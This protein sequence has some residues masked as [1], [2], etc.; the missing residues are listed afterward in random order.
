MYL[1]PRSFFLSFPRLLL[2]QSLCQ[3]FW[4][5]KRE[6]GHLLAPQARKRVDWKRVEAVVGKRRLRV[7]ALKAVGFNV[8][9]E[10]EGKDENAQDFHDRISK[11]D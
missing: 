10:A 4:D 9:N 3:N 2:I 5:P 7:E 6:E 11:I 1:N 8:G